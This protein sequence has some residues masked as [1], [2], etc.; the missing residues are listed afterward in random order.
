MFFLF[1]ACG[2]LKLNR[3]KFFQSLGGGPNSSDSNQNSTTEMFQTRLIPPLA[4]YLDSMESCLMAVA[5][6]SG[7]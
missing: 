7:L 6:N 1:Q 3:L 2:E 4:D 5:N